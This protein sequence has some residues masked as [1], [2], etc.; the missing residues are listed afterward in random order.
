MTAMLLL[1]AI[2]FCP[3]GSRS[4]HSASTSQKPHVTGWPGVPKFMPVKG[5]LPYLNAD[6]VNYGKLSHF[7]GITSNYFSS[8]GEIMLSNSY[9]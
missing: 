6:F 7:G 5:K 4:V 3:P 8:V 2:V 1:T 9:R